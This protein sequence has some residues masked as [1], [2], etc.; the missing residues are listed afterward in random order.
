ME[1][2]RAKVV[3]FDIGHAWCPALNDYVWFNREGFRHLIRKQGAPRSPEE[4]SRRLALIPYA[5]EII[6][7][8]FVATEHR[9]AQ[10][11]RI[12][13]THGN[14]I[15]ATQIH[16]WSLKARYNGKVITVV[17]RQSQGGK[18]HFLSIF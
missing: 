11:N 7:K 14:K 1:K 5:K 6:E 16:F 9:T 4:Q 12:V 2:Q 3:Y 13:R 8:T 15:G 10:S 18:K 17:I